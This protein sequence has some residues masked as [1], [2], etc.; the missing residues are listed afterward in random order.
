[1]STHT[2][3]HTHAHHLHMHAHHVQN[4]RAHAH[5]QTR[6]GTDTCVR[7]RT[8]THASTHTHTQHAHTHT[9]STPTPLQVGYDAAAHMSEETEGAAMAGPISL[10]A[11]IV[12]GFV[13]GFSYVIAL[14][15]SVQST[16]NVLSPD[17]ATA[18]GSAPMQIA[19]DVFAARFGSGAGALGLFVVPLLCSLFCGNACLTTCS[20][21]MWAFSRDGNLRIS[22]WLRTV[23]PKY[24]TPVNAVVRG[25]GVEECGRRGGAAKLGRGGKVV[26]RGC[27][28]LGW[29]PEDYQVAEDGAAHGQDARE[30]S[31]DGG[32]GGTW[33]GW[34]AREGGEGVGCLWCL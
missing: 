22:K 14:L 29:E 21:V 23:H 32:S 27:S 30:C 25:G 13:V 28:Q 18:G 8:H 26:C 16:D 33:E 4:T 9:H 20:R 15:F 31:G 11:T 24:K 7:T 34:G 19:W 12:S 17:A 2:N 10:I 1:M 3:N 6:T 5:A